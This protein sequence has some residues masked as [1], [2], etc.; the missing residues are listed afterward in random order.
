MDLLTEE[1]RVRKMKV[2][3][4]SGKSHVKYSIAL[5]FFVP[6][7]VVKNLKKVQVE[8]AVVFDWR[9]SKLAHCTLKAI[10]YR[11]GLPTQKELKTWISKARRIFSKQEP[12]EVTV[13]GMSKFPTALVAD[14]HSKD[15]LGLHRK[16]FKVLPSSQPQYEGR[17]YHPHV[18]IAM[19]DGEAWAHPPENKNF[20]KFKVDEIQLML[21]TMNFLNKPKVLWVVKL[22][23][24]LV[25][26]V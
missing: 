1:G 10:S 26:K 8:G 15:L 18:S 23:P 11:N 16:L 9:R 2:L 14:V 24:R 19:I 20:G 17:N 3:N 4:E 21:W 5:N 7:L 13:K 22:D 25:E 6:G 12:F